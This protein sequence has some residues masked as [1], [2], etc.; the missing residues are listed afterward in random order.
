MHDVKSI[1]K[2]LFWKTKKSLDWSS[3]MKKESMKSSFLISKRSICW[4]ENGLRGW[5]SKSKIWR[6]VKSKL[7]NKCF[8]KFKNYKSQMRMLYKASRRLRYDLIKYSSKKTLKYKK[9][10]LSYWTTRKTNLTQY[11]IWSK[12]LILLKCEI[13]FELK[14]LEQVQE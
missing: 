2:L 8:Y 5:K 9:L 10:E 3:W 11:E 1:R 4:I 14:K 12:C 7:I 6:K 13:R